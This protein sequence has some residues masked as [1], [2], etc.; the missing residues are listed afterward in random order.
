MNRLFFFIMFSLCQIS[1]AFGQGY[2]AS[3][4]KEIVYQNNKL[5]FKPEVALTP[6]DGLTES[7]VWKV[8]WYDS[9]GWIDIQYYG[10]IDA[11]VEFAIDYQLKS[12]NTTVGVLALSLYTPPIRR[13]GIKTTFTNITPSPNATNVSTS[14]EIPTSNDNV[15]LFL[16][17]QFCAAGDI[18]PVVMTINKSDKNDFYTTSCLTDGDYL[19][20]GWDRNALFTSNVKSYEIT[21]SS[22]REL[23]WVQASNVSFESYDRTDPD[24][25]TSENVIVYLYEGGEATADQLIGVDGNWFPPFTIGDNGLSDVFGPSDITNELDD[26]FIGQ[27]AVAYR[28][29]KGRDPNG[30]IFEPSVVEPAKE[31]PIKQFVHFEN[32]G[33]GFVKSVRLAN[34]LSDGYRNW[35][36]QSCNNATKFPNCPT[37]PATPDDILLDA[38]TTGS[39]IA[40]SGQFQGLF[41]N[42]SGCQGTGNLTFLTQNDLKAGDKI[43]GISTITMYQFSG[44]QNTVDRL[45]TDKAYVVVKNRPDQQLGFFLGVKTFFNTMPLDSATPRQRDLGFAF[46]GRL[47]LSKMNWGNVRGSSSFKQSDLPHW[48]YQCELG[49]SIALP[50][51]S[52]QQHHY[53]I[54]ITPIK[55]RYAAPYSGD[56]MLGA[57]L[58]YTGS[59]TFYRQVQSFNHTIDASLDVLNVLGQRGITLGIG[60]KGRSLKLDNVT[61]KFIQPYLYLQFNFAR[62]R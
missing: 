55:I 22:H 6:I 26:Q 41:L 40:G 53:N 42:Y 57:S 9:N 17:F 43:K 16:P 1:F 60:A 19:G 25:S 37:L 33:T 39:G 20:I 27:D 11:D 58:G 46:V 2:V 44:G 8:F 30:I 4:L 12:A 38:G 7:P 36:Y 23:I 18:I 62:F 14:P 32:N 54:D 5:K 35:A 29:G 48:W 34:S 3:E 21:G 28:P 13:E 51:Q 50:E 56:K 31:V 49:L 47:P 45:V 10:Q 15:N 52:S 59:L 24:N 61:H